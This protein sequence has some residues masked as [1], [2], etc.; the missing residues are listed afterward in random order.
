MDT[1]RWIVPLAL[2]A[3]LTFVRRAEASTQTVELRWRADDPTCIDRETLIRTVEATLG[4]TAFAVAAD[5]S[6]IIEGTVGAGPSGGFHAKITLRSASG[7]ILSEREV[8]T[9]AGKC[10]RIDESIA[11]VVALMVDGLE[12][13]PAPLE[14]PEAV[15]RPPTPPTPSKPAPKSTPKPAPRIPSEESRVPLYFEAEIG[16]SLALGLLPRSSVGGYLRGELGFGDAWSIAGAAHGFLSSR[17]QD[18]GATAAVHAWTF[19]V[20]ACHGPVRTRSMRLVACA[21]LG[22]GFAEASPSGTNRVDSLR[23]PLDYGGISFEASFRISGPLWLH[24]RPSL[25]T[26]L[27]SPQ[28]VTHTVD[29]RIHTIF[30]PWPVVPA[31]S[32][33]IGGR[34]GP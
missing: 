29:G 17:T 26:L 20:S 23:L 34:F 4:R 15:P 25:W 9:S 16:S 10:D 31:M 28:F 18:P 19:D 22:A 6:A 3:A 13:K 30:Q 12:D 1:R 5:G 21:L 2:V 11:I 14:V 33:G 27:Q 7:E 32:V 8:N 24:V